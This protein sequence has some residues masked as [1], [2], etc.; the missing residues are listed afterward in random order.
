M[1]NSWRDNPDEYYRDKLG[2]TKF[3]DGEIAML[4]AIPVSIHERKPIVVA[5]GHSL[6]KDFIF[7]KAVPYFLEAYGPCIVITTAPTDRQVQ[8]IM[9]GEI[10]GAYNNA[11]ITPPGKVLTQEIKITESWYALGF[12]TKETG[13]MI[14]KFQG[15]HS[16]RV[17]VIASE[18]QAIP[19]EI[20]DE[21]DGILTGEIGLLIM[22]GNPL[23]AAGRFARA[24]KDTKH[25]NV[26]TLSCLDNPNYTE[27]KTIVPGLTSYEWVEDK[28]IKWGEDDPRWFGRVLGQIPKT[29]IDSVFSESLIEKR[30]NAETF[31]V[32]IRRGVAIDVSR[33][34]DDETV[35]LGGTNGKVE[36][37]DIYGGEAGT[38]K[39]LTTTSAR[40]V[41]I[42]NKIGKGNFISVDADGIGA[43]CVDILNGMEVK[44]VVVNEI[45]SQGAS[46]SDEYY[47]LKAEMTF[48]ARKRLEEGKASLPNDPLLIEELL[49]IKYFINKKGKIQ[50][51]S[52][53]DIK[54]RLGRSPDRADAW[55]ILQYS[56]SNADP[57]K[58]K[59]GWSEQEDGSSKEVDVDL[60]EVKVGVGGMAG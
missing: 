59:D 51:E 11:K 7:G 14:G 3:W 57:V 4:Q 54:E 60:P 10:S 23:R 16:P 28:R 27:R 18:A 31:Q 33:F 53:E 1:I 58:N 36:A 52:K 22:I 43:G 30:I 44:G 25:N 50:I 5:S 12:T 42:H 40:A 55:I 9:W 56:F 41:M 34:G 35:I 47:N 46:I 24:I 45:H 37:S 8:K 29:S 19:D 49:E 26:I 32:Q 13:Q 6:G 17:F 39:A 21:V 15:F 48:V 2:I 38:G 20:F